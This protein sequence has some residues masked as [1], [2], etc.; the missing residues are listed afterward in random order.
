[1][2]DKMKKNEVMTIANNLKGKRSGTHPCQNDEEFVILANWIEK[3]NDMDGHFVEIGAYE[4]FTSE[5]IFNLKG[6]KK[7][8]FLCDTFEGLADVCEEDS[9]LG[10]PN[11]LLKVD[12][13]KFLQLNNFAD[14]STVTVVRGYFPDS[15]TA[16]MDKAKYCFVHID[17]DTYYSTLKS[18]EYF[19]SKMVSG[20]VIIVHDYMAHPGMRAVKKA[21][22]EFMSDKEDSLTTE[23]GSTQGII[24]KI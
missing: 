7:K 23:P 19:Y 8:L 4:G 17:T 14:D 1:M 15:S 2:E 24:V 6:A 22:N 12:Y 16:K 21:V 11:G 3:C 20:G 5:F 13:E 18:L 10:I 9:S